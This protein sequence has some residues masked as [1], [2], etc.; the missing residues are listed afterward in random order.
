MTVGGGTVFQSGKTIVGMAHLPPLP[1]APGYDPDGGIQRLVDW[2]SADLEALQSGGIDA[3]MFGNEADR[4]YVL[5]APPEGLA[6]MTAVVT[7]VKP[8]LTV[9]FGV[10]YLW[11]PV[12]SVALAV[13]TGA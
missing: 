7:D 13:A 5:H 12:A 2:V 1:G 8:L 3:V 10:N 9:P 6:A 11:D 4:P